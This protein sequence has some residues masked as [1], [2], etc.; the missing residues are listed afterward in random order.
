MTSAPADS[1]IHHAEPTRRAHVELEPERRAEHP[2]LLHRGDV[3]LR[4]LR[5][6]SP[7]EQHGQGG[8]G[9]ENQPTFG[10]MSRTEFGL[11][12]VSGTPWR[13]RGLDGARWAEGRR[14]GVS[15]Y[16]DGGAKE[17]GSEGI[18]LKIAGEFW[19]IDP[20]IQQNG[21][22]EVEVENGVRTKND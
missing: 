21:A 8:T 15:R 5:G 2:E 18:L 22:V 3:P 16:R 4:E 14:S 11:P 10:P 12:G 1:A 6:E 17:C 13:T 7:T 20:D 9:S 19:P